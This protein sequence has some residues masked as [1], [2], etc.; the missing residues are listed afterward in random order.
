MLNDCCTN[1]IESFILRFKFQF[2]GALE[3]SMDVVSSVVVMLVLALGSLFIVLF[4]AFQLHGETVHLIKLAT[5][6]LSTQPD[7]L[8]SAVNYTEGQL[9]EHDIDDYVE[10]VRLRYLD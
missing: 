3:Q 8:A 10:Q 6:V 2:V 5:N 9:A 4:V 7:W 1:A